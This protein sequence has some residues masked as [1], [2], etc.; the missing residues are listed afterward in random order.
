MCQCEKHNI[1]VKH[2]DIL[3]WINFIKMTA[4]ENMD[5]VIMNT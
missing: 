1:S 5:H 4:L 3:L 2:T